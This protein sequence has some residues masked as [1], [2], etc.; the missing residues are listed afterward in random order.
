MNASL[1]CE[2]PLSGGNQTNWRSI[3]LHQKQIIAQNQ[4]PKTQCQQQPVHFAP[5]GPTGRRPRSQEQQQEQVCQ[6]LGTPSFHGQGFARR[7]SSYHP[8]ATQDLVKSEA[9][10]SPDVS[11]AVPLPA[12]SMAPINSCIDTIQPTLTCHARPYPPLLSANEGQ[13][14]TNE[15]RP[16]RPSQSRRFCKFCGK[17]FTRPANLR[18]HED[19]HNGLRRHHCA[20]TVGHKGCNLSFTRLTD[21]KRHTKAKHPGADWPYEKKKKGTKIKEEEESE[22]SSQ[23][24]DEDTEEKPKM[25]EADENVE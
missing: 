14:S 12:F 16:S 6:A 18:S 11:G 10:K 7:S 23:L 24:N 1:G 9:L 4:R 25:C 13:T 20:K 15:R 5:Y 22:T 19:V 2:Q 8:A 21:L 3:Q 17:G